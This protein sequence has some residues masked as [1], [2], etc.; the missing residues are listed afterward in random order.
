MKTKGE[1]V[2]V[3]QFDF[4]DHSGWSMVMPLGVNAISRE[5]LRTQQDQ[6]LERKIICGFGHLLSIF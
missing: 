5:K 6:I 1:M 4:D 3:A 2:M